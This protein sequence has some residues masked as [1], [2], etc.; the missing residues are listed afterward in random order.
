MKYRA[1]RQQQ[2]F[3]TV[4]EDQSKALSIPAPIQSELIVL[5]AQLMQSVILRDGL[6]ARPSIP[7]QLCGSR[8]D[9]PLMRTV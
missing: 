6:V 5:L 1:V 4:V 8:N 9:G 2:L 7:S 3:G